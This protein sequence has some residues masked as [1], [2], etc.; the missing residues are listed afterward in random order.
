MYDNV[1]CVQ[2]NVL[3]MTLDYRR[4]HLYDTGILPTGQSFSVYLYISK[5]TSYRVNQVPNTFGNK[6]YDYEI[7]QTKF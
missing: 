2:S 6:F 1:L 5:N 7:N 3:I 4:K